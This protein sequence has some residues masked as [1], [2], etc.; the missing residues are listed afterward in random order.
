MN[1]YSLRSP[2]HS[3]V[4]SSCI[5]H[6]ATET[7]PLEKPGVFSCLSISGEL[8]ISGEWNDQFLGRND[9]NPVNHLL[10]RTNFDG[11]DISNLRFLEIV[12]DDFL[13]VLAFHRETALTICN[14][15]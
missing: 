7:L 10:A 9:L 15:L 12:H 8:T 1:R 11:L 5:S 6:A 4:P 14:N 13:S 2:R 3:T